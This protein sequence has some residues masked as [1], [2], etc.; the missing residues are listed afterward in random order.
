M[1]SISFLLDSAALETTRGSPGG[2]FQT[3]GAP[4]FGRHL[5]SSV[6]NQGLEPGLNVVIGSRAGKESSLVFQKCPARNVIT[7]TDSALNL[8]VMKRLHVLSYKRLWKYSNEKETRKPNDISKTTAPLAVPNALSLFSQRRI[9]I[10]FVFS[11]EKSPGREQHDRETDLR[12][13][14]WTF[15]WR[16][17]LPLLNVLMDKLHI[18]YENKHCRAETGKLP[19]HPASVL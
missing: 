9:I 15:S 5:P 12:A 2:S 14:R 3:Y 17:H 6:L 1:A 19:S 13:C 11:W 18:I 4:P 7:P 16:C 10:H 8:R